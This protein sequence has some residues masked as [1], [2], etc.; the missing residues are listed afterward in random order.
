MEKSLSFSDQDREE[1]QA[2]L[3]GRENTF[4]CPILIERI[5]IRAKWKHALCDVRKQKCVLTGKMT[6]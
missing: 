6:N 4:K 1:F 3:I 2:F 5:W